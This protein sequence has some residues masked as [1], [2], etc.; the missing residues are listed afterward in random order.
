MSELAGADEHNSAAGNSTRLATCWLFSGCFS[1]KA[2]LLSACAI[3]QV[4][5]H[6]AATVLFVEEVL[7]QIC[8]V[9]NVGVGVSFCSW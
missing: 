4:D 3:L 8:E 9:L 6:T 1:F 7:F 2:R 5:H